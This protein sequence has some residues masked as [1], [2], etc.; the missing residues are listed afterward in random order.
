MTQYIGNRKI[1][2]AEERGDNM[3]IT[4]KTSKGDKLPNKIDIK[5]KLFDLIVTTALQEGDYIR[6][7]HDKLAR[8]FIKELALTDLPMNSV[9]TVAQYMVAISANIAK[10]AIGKKFGYE[11]QDEVTMMD[12]LAANL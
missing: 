2:L 6:I 1:V 10:E 4:F 9:A 7:C 8:Y 11:H 3:Q 12:I 5:K